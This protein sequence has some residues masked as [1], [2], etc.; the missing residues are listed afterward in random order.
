MY[1]EGKGVR[2]DYS[3]AYQL[4]LTAAYKGNIKAQLALGEMHAKGEGIYQS[5]TA[6]KEWFGKAC[7]NGSQNGCDGYRRLNQKSN[8]LYS[9]YGSS[10]YNQLR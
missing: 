7:D 8:S 1:R 3:Q 6:A 2:Q 10:I 4:F 5:N 9:P